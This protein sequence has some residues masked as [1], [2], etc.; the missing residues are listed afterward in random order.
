[1]KN[2][3]IRLK[4][5]NGKEKPPGGAE[6]FSLRGGIATEAVSSTKAR[7]LTTLWFGMTI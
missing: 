2:P 6:K 7:F 1:M 5:Q 4:L 3:N